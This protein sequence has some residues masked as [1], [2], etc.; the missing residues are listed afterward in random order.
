MASIEVIKIKVKRGDIY[1]I[2]S[3]DKHPE[4]GAEIWSERP[5]IIVSNN[6]TNKLDGAV[7]IVYM[8]T[9]KAKQTSPVHVLITSDN[10]NTMA[11]C[12]QIHTVDKSRLMQKLGKITEKEKEKIDKALA[13]SLGINEKGYRT[14][15]KKWENYVKN[16]HL[17][18]SE[19]C[20]AIKDVERNKTVKHLQDELEIIRNERD[21]WKT[22]AE[23][24][25]KLLERFEKC[26]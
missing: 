15:F 5:A 12:E 18:I 13:M 21:G 2:K 23:A 20:K 9:S 25:Q 11:L 1:Y 10:R 16:Y 6:A 17:E 8:S 22:I 3:D 14:V 24:K 19:E 7:C 26:K 4:V